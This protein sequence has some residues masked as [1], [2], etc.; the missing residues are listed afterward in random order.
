MKLAYQINESLKVNTQFNQYT[1]VYGEYWRGGVG[2][3]DR[4]YRNEEASVARGLIT[5]PRASEGLGGEGS[6]EGVF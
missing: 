4:T 2:S 3:K 1:I 6:R 5:P